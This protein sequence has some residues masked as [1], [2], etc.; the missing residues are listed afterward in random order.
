MDFIKKSLSLTLLILFFSSSAN[1]SAIFLTCYMN[2]PNAPMGSPHNVEIYPSGK[3]FK[4]PAVNVIGNL[5]MS[6]DWYNG[7]YEMDVNVKFYIDRNSG[8]ITYVL[9]ADGRE[10]FHEGF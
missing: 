9:S 3:M 7:T 4:I 5:R 1:A 2:D 8:A 6:R 10:K